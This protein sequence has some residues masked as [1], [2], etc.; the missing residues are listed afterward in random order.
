MIGI[1][2]RI[3]VGKGAVDNIVEYSTR[4]D[5]ENKEMTVEEVIPE[6]LNQVSAELKCLDSF[7]R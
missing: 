2:L 6:I 3:T 4:K 1:P 5:M 7:Y